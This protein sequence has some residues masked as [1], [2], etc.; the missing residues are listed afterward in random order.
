MYRSV[1]LKAVS[2]GAYGLKAA[3]QDKNIG[4]VIQ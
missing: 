2:R 3:F 1:Y 4:R